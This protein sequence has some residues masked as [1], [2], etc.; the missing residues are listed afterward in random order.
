MEE[1]CLQAVHGLA[2]DEVVGAVDVVEDGGHE[3]VVAV[4]APGQQ[5]CIG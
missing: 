3:D 1:S 4:V 5:V 2:A